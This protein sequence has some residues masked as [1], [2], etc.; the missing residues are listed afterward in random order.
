MHSNLSFTA[1]TTANGVRERDF[2]LGEI[3]GVLWTPEAAVEGAPLIL[4]GHPGGLHKKARGVVDRARAYVTACG[5]TAASIDAPGHGDR[6]RSERD[7]RWVAAMF[8]AREAGE[9]IG[10]IVAEYNGS[11]ADRAVPEWRATL[12]AL[13]AL[14]EIGTAAPVG[15][16]GM[17][18]ASATGIPLAAADSRISAAVFGGVL[19]YDALTEAA[20][21]VTIPIQFI[22]PWDDPE[23]D[24]QSQLDLYDAFGSKE[25]SLHANPG[26]HF[27]VP[28]FETEDSIRFFRRHLDPAAVQPA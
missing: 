28:W 20:R 15:F 22:L 4:M 13:R 6:P 17:T 9:P 5:Y 3:T 26:S 27:V 7:Q 21:R 19:V 23:I 16:S 25:K 18:L 12:D 14:A 10:P 2:T 8:A 1:E 11:L 24:R